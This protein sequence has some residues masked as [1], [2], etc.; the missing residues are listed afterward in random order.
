M[1][2]YTNIKRIVAFGCS[3]TGGCELL[4]HTLAEPYVSLK[5]RL[6]PYEW[7]NA[8]S[9]DSKAFDTLTSNRQKE[10]YLAWPA[11]L[12]N[13][14]QLDFLSLAINGNSNEKAIWQIEKAIYDKTIN[15]TDLVIV[16]LTSAHR[17]MFFSND[18]SEPVPF[19]L[20]NQDVFQSRYKGALYDWFDDSRIL[21]NYLRDLDQFYLL[22][23]KLG[24]RLAVVHTESPFKMQEAH[25][26]GLENL[27]H[28]K[29]FFKH[30][31]DSILASGLFLDTQLHLYQFAEV[32]LSHGHPNEDAHQ[33]FADSLVKCFVKNS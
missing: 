29:D 25:Y 13:N 26:W 12:A 20:S 1:V 16:G 6:S 7:Y 14:L 33:K 15:N 31:L 28:Q 18:H 27:G 17:S 11:K 22:K 10:K 5:E 2:N 32:K 24:G 30:K 8:I 23:K 3:F 21:W 19:L 4:D 9:K